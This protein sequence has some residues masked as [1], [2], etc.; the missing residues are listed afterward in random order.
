ME[1]HASYAVFE[2]IMLLSLNKFVAEILLTSLCTVMVSDN[3]VMS[4]YKLQAAD[5]KKILTSLL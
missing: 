2:K 5:V 1:A 3:V 4:C